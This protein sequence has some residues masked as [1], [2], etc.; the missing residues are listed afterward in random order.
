MLNIPARRIQGIEGEGFF[1]IHIDALH[2]WRPLDAVAE[3]YTS[4]GGTAED[5]P[6]AANQQIQ[7]IF[8]TKRCQKGPS[9]LGVASLLLEM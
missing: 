5:V 4:P 6:Q 3:S 9:F 1:Y 2:N 8:S 7:S